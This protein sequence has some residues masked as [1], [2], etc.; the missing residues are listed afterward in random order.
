MERGGVGTMTKS[1]FRQ[2]VAVILV[3]DTRDLESLNKLHEWA[4]M[5]EETC[6][7][8]EHLTYA[9]WGNDKGDIFSNVNNPVEQYHLENLQRTLPQSVKIEPQLVCTLNGMEDHESVVGYYETLVRMLDSR[10]LDIERRLKE[11]SL[12]SRASEYETDNEDAQDTHH[13]DDEVH[14]QNT[15]GCWS[16]C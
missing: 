3:Y 14:E 2:A 9:L 8:K 7:Y 1:Y 11:T 5:A 6:D 16:K 12:K 15:G 4:K 10:M 13:L